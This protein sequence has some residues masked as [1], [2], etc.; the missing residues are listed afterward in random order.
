M[1]NLHLLERV[2][3][4]TALPINLADVKAQLRIEHDD[5]NNYL[6]RLINAAIAMVDAKGILGQAMITQTWAQWL[7]YTPDR[8]ILLAIG[9]VQSVDAV[10]YYD[11]N[12]DLQTDTLANYD[13]FGLSYNKTVKPKTGYNW[14][15]TQVR[16]D[17]IKI[18]YVIGYGDAPTDVPDTIRHA[19]LMLVAYWY[20]NRENELI[21]VNSKT[22]PFGFEDLLNLHRERFYG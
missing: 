15:T 7:P 19:M 22:L 11:T 2:T 8:E 5:E 4:P 13:V 20:E 9:P 6:D 12:G 10:K 21:G 17:A 14:P 3:G 1:N 16:Q 18:E